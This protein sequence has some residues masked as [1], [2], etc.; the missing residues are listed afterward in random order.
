M[1]R[2]AQW[3]SGPRAVPSVPWAPLKN[4]ADWGPSAP[5]STR[6]VPSQC[7][8]S[9]ELPSFSQSF[10]WPAVVR[11]DAGGTGCGCAQQRPCGRCTTRP[12][13]RRPRVPRCSQF[14]VGAMLQFPPQC[15]PPLQQ[16]LCL[17]GRCLERGRGC[18]RL[19]WPRTP[20]SLC[21]GLD[22]TRLT[23]CPSPV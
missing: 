10:F 20:A 22:W 2:P 4:F 21:M 15:P 3:G 8:T 1:A 5:S 13:Q 17:P 16:E 7:S 14:A 6:I 23:H 18:V 19:P 9:L 12:S 11:E